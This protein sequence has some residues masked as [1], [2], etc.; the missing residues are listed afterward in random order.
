MGVYGDHYLFA[1]WAG[2]HLEAAQ[3]GLVVDADIT[4][5]V[6]CLLLFAVALLVV[7][8]MVIDLID[9]GLK[10]TDVNKGRVPLE[11]AYLLRQAIALLCAGA[12]NLAVAADIVA[13]SADS[14]AA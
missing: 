12:A 11:A 14:G 8:P 5:G 4:R 13:M 10:F 2:D 1:R 6:L 7:I 3:N 9:E